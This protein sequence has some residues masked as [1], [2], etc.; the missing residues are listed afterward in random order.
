MSSFENGLHNYVFPLAVLLAKGSS[1]A[2]A[3]LYLGSLYS[4]LDEC[5]QSVLKSINRYDVVTYAGVSFLQMFLQ[6]RL[7]A[8]WP[9]SVEFK[10]VKPEKIAL[11]GVEKEKLPTTSLK[12]LGGRG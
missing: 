6:E 11:D 9:M 8:L 5:S 10:A 12:G 7:G 3:P 1:L 2:L 4:R